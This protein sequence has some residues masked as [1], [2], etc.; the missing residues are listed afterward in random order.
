[1]INQTIQNYLKV[2]VNISIDENVDQIKVSNIAK[3]LEIS[4][5][6]VTD[7]VRKLEA[8]GYVKNEPYK[9]VRLTE[10]GKHVG[11]NMIRHHRLW[12]VFLTEELGMT[13][14]EVH[15]EAERLEHA[16][17]DALMDK[18]EEKLGYPT[19]DPHGK[20]IPRLSKTQ[21]TGAKK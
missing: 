12:E 4:V 8:D 11:L 14:D 10:K 9:G 6:A 19:E 5:P 18:I 21:G 13:E 15:D 2:I 3:R 1:M 16:C 7:K 17:S 20:P